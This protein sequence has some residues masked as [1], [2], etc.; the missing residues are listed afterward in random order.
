MKEKQ[1]KEKQN[2]GDRVKCV[3]LELKSEEH[4]TSTSVMLEPTS[5]QSMEHGD[6]IAA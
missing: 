3:R 5:S 2:S 4:S 1:K 6:D